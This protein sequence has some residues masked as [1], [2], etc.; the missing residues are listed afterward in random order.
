MSRGR[1][2]TTAYVGI[3][4]SALAAALVLAPWHGGA[5]VGAL[6]LACVPAGA[7]VMCWFDVGETVAQ[8]GLTLI[9]SL[10]AL[11]IVSALMIWAHASEPKAL[12][13]LAA[14]SVLSCVV[15]LRRGGLQ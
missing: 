12:L 14:A 9:I 5:V 4:A 11:A 15:R 1:T 13:A 3:L 8:A 10:A 2:G 7:S 6:M